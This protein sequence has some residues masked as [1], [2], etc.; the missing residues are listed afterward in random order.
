MFFIVARWA[1]LYPHDDETRANLFHLDAAILFWFLRFL[2]TLK[3]PNDFIWK[4]KPAFDDHSETGD[5]AR[6]RDY[7]NF[8]INL[9]SPSLYEDEYE[10]KVKE[11]KQVNHI[12]YFEIKDL[13]VHIARAEAA[14]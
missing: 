9:T 8:L 3:R 1:L 5:I 12:Q 4:R 13:H 7:R 14:N 10:R 11:L 2:C 6:L